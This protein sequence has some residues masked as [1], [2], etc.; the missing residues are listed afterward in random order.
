M[1][2]EPK[3]SKEEKLKVAEID[4][5][6]M[7]LKNYFEEVLV[8]ELLKQPIRLD[9]VESYAAKMLEQ[10]LQINKGKTKNWDEYLKEKEAMD[11]KLYLTNLN[12]LEYVEKV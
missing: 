3:L 6:Q 8:P 12:Q 11:N 9:I 10:L 5:H 4:K 2:K 1:Y 7:L